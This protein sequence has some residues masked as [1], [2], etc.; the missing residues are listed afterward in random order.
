MPK[1]I[2]LN[3]PKWR[4]ERRVTG[5]YAVH[6]YSR[7]NGIWLHGDYKLPE[8]WHL[9]PPP[10]Q[11]AIKKERPYVAPDYIRFDENGRRVA[12]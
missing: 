10:V 5:Y 9:L 2:E 11:E 7:C 8:E 12:G 4:L 1:V 6:Q 3:V